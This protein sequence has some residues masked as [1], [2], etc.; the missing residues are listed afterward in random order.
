MWST[1]QLINR[2]SFLILVMV[3][4]FWQ[5]KGNDL[6]DSIRMAEKVLVGD[7]P[8]DLNQKDVYLDRHRVKDMKW[9]LKMKSLKKVNVS[10]NPIHNI[11]PLKNNQSIQHLSIA[12]TYIEDLSPLK[13]VTTLKYLAVHFTKVRH[14]DML[15]A[16]LE[17]LIIDERVDKKS[18]E[19]YK[20]KNPKCK[21]L[22][23]KMSQKRPFQG[24]N[25]YWEDDIRRED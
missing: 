21:I 8:V 12:H 19:E 4:V 5:C 11:E 17:K 13:D 24:P 1:I 14:V 20:K 23:W 2:T 9:V 6:D 3:T 25:N 7:T 16:S 18:L 10:Q 22:I 15:P